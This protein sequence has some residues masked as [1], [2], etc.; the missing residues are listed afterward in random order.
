[1]VKKGDN[2]NMWNTIYL[3]FLNVREGNSVIE[4]TIYIA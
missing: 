1:M 2:E 3:E 4:Y